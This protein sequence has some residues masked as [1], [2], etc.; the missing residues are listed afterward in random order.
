MRLRAVHEEIVDRRLSNSGLD[1]RFVE[2]P[3][4]REQIR[5]LRADADVRWAQLHRAAKRIASA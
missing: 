5:E 1:E 4:Q 3:L 2:A